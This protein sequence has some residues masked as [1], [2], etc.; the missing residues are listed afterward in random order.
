MNSMQKLL[1]IN[2]IYYTP[3][4]STNNKY[5]HLTSAI[6]IQI[7]FHT[8][9]IY[10]TPVCAFVTILAVSFNVKIRLMSRI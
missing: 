1:F 7:I 3:V 9:E 10:E 5:V 8:T 4:T 6:K 2:F